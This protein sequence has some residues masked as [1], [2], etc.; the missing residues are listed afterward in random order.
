MLSRIRE[1]FGKAGLT[2]AVVALVMALVGGAYAAG[3]LTGKQKKEVEKIAKKFA[4]KPGAPGATGPAGPAGPAGAKGDTG[5]AG[6]NGTNGTNGAPGESV[7]IAAASVGECPQ[8][9]TKFSNKTGSGKAC[10]GQTGFT[11]T[12]PPSKTET[13]TWS[14]LEIQV[15][16]EKLFPVP[17]S[18]P[19]PLSGTVTAVYLNQEE[20][21]EEAETGGCKWEQGNAT[22][23]PEAPAGTLCVFTQEEEKSEL[24][25]SEFP[26]GVQYF[27][28]PGKPSVTEKAGPAGAHM[29][30]QIYGEPGTPATVSG[31]GAWAVTAPTS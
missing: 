29:W 22:A 17:I 18:F 5:A 19:I 16:W 13:G 27:T 28:P 30:V 1:P 20:T 2:V 7:S 12:L 11:E 14:M 6:A 25:G 9:G 24:F 4:G 23:E 10:N 8:G 21:K 3:A 15:E 26:E 31:Y